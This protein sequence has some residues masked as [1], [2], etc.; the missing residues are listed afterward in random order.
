MVADDAAILGAEPAHLKTILKINTLGQ[1]KSRL[2]YIKELAAINDELAQHGDLMGKS[3]EFCFGRDATLTWYGHESR[4]LD[5]SAIVAGDYLVGLREEGLCCNGI[6]PAR[7]VLGAKHGE[8]WGQVKL[9]GRHLAES[10]RF[11]PLGFT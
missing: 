2:H 3:D 6:S 11:D 7:A 9:G 8:D 10:W 5:G 4:L 1:S